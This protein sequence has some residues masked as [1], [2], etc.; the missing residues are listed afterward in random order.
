MQD[1]HVCSRLVQLRE[2]T[3]RNIRCAAGG[4]CRWA[5]R[6]CSGCCPARPARRARASQ[7]QR[8]SPPALPPA[9]PHPCHALPRPRRELLRDFSY[10]GIRALITLAVAICLGTLYANQGQEVGT[11]TGA[12]LAGGE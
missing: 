9:R 4:R 3:R 11:Y 12:R 6:A 7:L 5:D 8:R 10:N 1:L 2:L